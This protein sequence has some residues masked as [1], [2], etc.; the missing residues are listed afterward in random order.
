MGHMEHIRW[1]LPLTTANP[2]AHGG[3]LFDLL[4]ADGVVTAADVLP[5]RLHRGAEKL[6]E[7]RDYRACLALANRHDWLGSF[8]SELSLAQLLEQMLGI[9]V[10][11]RAQWLRTLLAEYARISH[12]LL[13]LSAALEV[14]GQPAQAAVGSAAREGVVD[15]IERLA[16]T[17]MHPMVV[18]IGGLRADADDAWLAA[19]VTALAPARTAA[20]A[21]VAALAEP[22]LGQADLAVLPATVAWDFAASGPV[23]RAAGV[24]LDLRLDRPDPCYAELVADGVLRRVVRGEGDSLARYQVLAHEVAV[25][26]DC[27]AACADRLADLAGQPV[28][29]PLP[30]SVRVPEGS[31]YHA[32]ENPGG[33]NG[34]FLVSRGGPMP[35]RLKLRTSSF[36]NAAALAV[37][38]PGTPVDSLPAAVTSFFLIAGDIDR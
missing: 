8:G 19:V 28:S 5:G 22:A 24:P 31:G 2:A 15:G 4:V 35:H 3:P 21:M 36:N 6:F 1:S 7:S 11:P 25:S 12:H 20:D 34:W 16:G 17:R 29:V 38:L 37:A 32:G 33:S 14:A 13:W 10:P 9:T 26:A 18:R 27:V 30:R 23:A